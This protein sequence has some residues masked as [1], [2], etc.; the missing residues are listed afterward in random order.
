MKEESLEMRVVRVL[1]LLEGTIGSVR[2]YTTD[3]LRRRMKIVV[4]TL[5]NE[6]C[7]DLWNKDFE[8]QEYLDKIVRFQYDDDSGEINGVQ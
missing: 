6:D 7:L 3:D 8:R 1:G 2:E 4:R 5:K